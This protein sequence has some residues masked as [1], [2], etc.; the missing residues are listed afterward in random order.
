VFDVGSEDLTDLT[1]DGVESEDIDLCA[2]TVE[3][4]AV[5]SREANRGSFTPISSRR[6]RRPSSGAV[7]HDQG[8]GAHGGPQ[9]DPGILSPRFAQ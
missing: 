3:R 9:P 4:R 1:D 8:R 6:T 7:G 2:T 5:S